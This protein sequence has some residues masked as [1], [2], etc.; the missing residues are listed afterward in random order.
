MGNAKA[1]VKR[2]ADEVTL[3]CDEDGVAVFLELI[4]PVWDLW[5]APASALVYKETVQQLPFAFPNSPFYS[6][7]HF[8]TG[9]LW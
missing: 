9:K 6:G 5:Y 1:H 7:W 2:A 8:S 4:K 3:S